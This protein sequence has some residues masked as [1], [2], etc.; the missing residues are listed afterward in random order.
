MFDWPTYAP[1]FDGISRDVSLCLQLEYPVFSR[2]HW[3]RTGKDRVQVEATGV[4]V[5]RPST[6]WRWPGRARRR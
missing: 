1:P 5:N 2:D 3:M 6:G 4:P